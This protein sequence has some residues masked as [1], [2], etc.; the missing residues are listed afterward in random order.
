VR[1]GLRDRAHQALAKHPFDALFLANLMLLL[2]LS[3][4]QL[5]ETHLI[6]RSQQ[7]LG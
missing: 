4:T 5:S 2:T 3:H 1:S 6:I 7:N